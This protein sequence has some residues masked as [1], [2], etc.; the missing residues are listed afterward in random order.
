MA[1][2]GDDSDDEDEVRTAKVKAA[3]AGGKKRQITIHDEDE[4]EVGTAKV[5]AA[6]AG[7]KQRW[8]RGA[9]VAAVAK[10]DGEEKVKVKAG[11]SESASK[12][13]RRN[14]TKSGRRGRHERSVT[15]PWW[16][17]E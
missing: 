5:K 12:T 3:K 13:W 7:R 8:Q 2:H 10:R 15:P 6:K 9:A 17:K 1:E 14:K 16:R 4:D 11:A